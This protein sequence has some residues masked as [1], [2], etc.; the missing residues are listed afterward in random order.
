VIER[1]NEGSV[2][3]LTL[4]HGTANAL[5]LELCEA[6]AAED[7]AYEASAERAPRGARRGPRLC[8]G[9]AGDGPQRTYRAGWSRARTGVGWEG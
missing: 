8:R 9:K 2:R 3:V 6:L 4:A 5:D 7:A 1:A